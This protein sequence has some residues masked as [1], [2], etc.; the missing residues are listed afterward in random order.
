MKLYQAIKKDN[1]MY[2]KEA[3][4]RALASMDIVVKERAREKLDLD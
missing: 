2:S 1:E 4:M 3:L